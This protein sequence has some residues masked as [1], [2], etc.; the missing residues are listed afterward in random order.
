M[1]TS[2]L[3]ASLIALASHANSGVVYDHND[4]PRI[5]EVSG[6]NAALF[7][8]DYRGKTFSARMP[9]FNVTQTVIQQDFKAGFGTGLLPDVECK[10]TNPRTLG[11][12][13]DASEND[14]FF[15]SGRIK[16]T[17]LGVLQLED[18]KIR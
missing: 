3:A 7:V 14:I 2:I 15:V 11:Q 16:D 13:A 10:I 8:R 12:L 5:K 4:L 9:F 6:N 1:K 17:I 18:C